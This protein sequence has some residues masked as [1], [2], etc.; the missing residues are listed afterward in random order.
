MDIKEIQKLH[1]GLHK[2]PLLD[3]KLLMPELKNNSQV[4]LDANDFT[5]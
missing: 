3:A 4:Y 2:T 1:C 5:W